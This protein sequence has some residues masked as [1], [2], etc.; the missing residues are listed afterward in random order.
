V[1]FR[2]LGPVEVSRDGHEQLVAEL[3]E[4][5]GSHPTRDRLVGQLMLALYRC[6]RQAEALDRY[7]AARA[8]R[9]DELGLDPS[10]AGAV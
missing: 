3:R 8:V 4:L 7:R 6:G 9:R 5:A 10:P 1:E 2:I